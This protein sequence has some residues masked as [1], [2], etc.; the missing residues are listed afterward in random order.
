ME[1]S[2]IKNSYTTG[3]V[4]GTNIVGG[5]AGGVDDSAITNSYATGN[6]GER[7]DQN[8]GGIA[9]G[10]TGNSVIKNSYATGYV[11]GD[12]RVGGIAGTVLENSAIT[13]SYAT[14]NVSG[15]GGVGGIAGTVLEHSAITNSAAIN[16]SVMGSDRVNRIVGYIDG[17]GNT[18]SNNFALSG[19][20][21]GKNYNGT[22]NSFTDSGDQSYH[23]TDKSDDLLKMQSTYSNAVNGDGFG[24]LGWDFND[25]WKIDEG[26]SYPILKW[27]E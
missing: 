27:Q 25:V 13:D 23:G 10:V 11:S 5:I 26:N 12:F 1:S 7:D 19:M 6:V 24:G 3:Y 14:G 20:R 17:G 9:G 15:N 22:T 16:G 8:V 2:V 18:I 21:G 4:H